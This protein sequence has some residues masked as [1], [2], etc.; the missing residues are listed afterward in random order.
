LNRLAPS[1]TGI[2]V[3]DGVIVAVGGEDEIRYHCDAATEFVDGAGLTVVPG[4]VDAHHHPMWVTKFVAGADASAIRDLTVLQHALRAERRK[5]GEEG[6]A[7]A[8]GLD[9]AL[10]AHTGLDG[11]ELE[12]L[13]E[14]PALVTFM[15]CHTY[16]A[17]P[18]VLRRA[19]I[20]ARETFRDRSE[21]VMQGEVP[22]GELRE[23]E[24]FERVSRALPKPSE[25]QIVGELRETFTKLAALG[26]AGVHVMD[27]DPATYDLLDLVE[28]QE[29][30]PLR[31]VVP[32]WIKPFTSDD[33]IDHLVHLRGARGRRWRGGVS[34]FFL[35]GVVESGTAWLEKP[36]AYGGCE[37]S[38][39]PDPARYSQLVTRFARAGFQCVTHAI[40][41]RAIRETLDAYHVA[42]PLRGIRH[43]IEH[44]ETLTDC[45]LDRLVKQRVVASMQPLH[46]Q[47][48]AADGSDEWARRLG[49]ERSGRA[50]RAAD[51]LR[52][53]GTLALGSDWPVADRD[54]RI[55][56]AWARL[57]RPPGEPDAHVFEPHQRLTAREA[58]KGYTSGSAV[59]VGD[60]HNLGKIRPGMQADLTAFAGN[61]LQVGGDEII[62]VPVAF[63]AVAGRITHRAE[64]DS[65]AQTKRSRRVRD[66]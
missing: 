60:Q 39:W 61:P 35:D 9:Y 34:K 65:G 1:A 17:T 8:W 46:M 66:D 14:G 25:A 56:M 43:R 41:D 27:G 64:V 5:V 42:P 26:L 36:D 29:D 51:I 23:F 15:D 12:R 57:R 48:R 38:A 22:T 62:D 13:A 52:A 45:E 54:P 20:T 31:L 21:V 53:G 11:R 30:L 58:L 37:A 6:I 32:L 63:T 50:F 49:E 40:G 2:A 59:A 44:L 55:G 4:L 19:G 18:A 33:E 7:R 28:S 24:A 47:W 16:L 3:K 10:F